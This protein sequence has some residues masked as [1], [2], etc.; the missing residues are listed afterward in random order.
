M[1][2]EDLE[3]SISLIRDV[4]L[5]TPKINIFHIQEALSLCLK[6]ETSFMDVRHFFQK[7]KFSLPP[8]TDEQVQRMIDSK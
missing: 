7:N 3:N 6:E 8:F 1:T 2:K 4:M 5:S